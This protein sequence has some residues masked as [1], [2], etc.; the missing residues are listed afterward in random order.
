MRLDKELQTLVQDNVI[1]LE[2][3]N[4]IKAYYIAKNKEKP[5]LLF[6]VFGIFGAL[7]I[8][9]GIILMIA[10]NWDNFSKITKTI[11]AFAP[12]VIAQSLVGFSIFKNK[13]KAWKEASGTFLFFTVGS[14]ISMISQ[15]Y[16]V[17]GSLSSFLIIWTI[18][19]IPLLYLLRSHA[20]ALL[21]L[22]TGTYYALA[23]KI[24]DHKIIEAP[25]VYMAF[26]LSILPY[27]ISLL[28]RNA[29]SNAVTIFSWMLPLSLM[30]GS[31]TFFRSHDHMVFVLYVITFGILYNIGKFSIFKEVKRLRNGFLII[32]SLGTIILLVVTT[33]QWIWGDLLDEVSSYMGELFNVIIMG[34]IALLALGYNIF[35]KGIRS[36]NL[37]QVAFVVFVLIYFL[38]YQTENIPVI[39]MNLLVFALGVSTVI[40][41]AQ[42]FN[43]GLLNFG[44]LIVSILIICRFFDTEINFVL[45]GF[46]FVLVG[47]GF[48][49]SNYI[50]LKRKKVISNT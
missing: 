38:L 30:I 50:M 28:K 36:I 31:L 3:S 48:F 47:L 45:K 46:A 6:L 8:G 9:S 4:K 42:K 40:S 21:V 34:T 41:G 20:V 1:S 44:L 16:N 12:L 7:L 33:F 35:R 29:S 23:A 49:F 22:L 15:I 43:F 14:S 27:Y 26:F 18:L 10:H 32:G 11:F 25:W 2:T 5:N 19:C 24:W 13:G 39:L 17:S 37:F